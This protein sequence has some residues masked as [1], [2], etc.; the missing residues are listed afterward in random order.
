MISVVDAA[1]LIS[2]SNFSPFLGADQ[3]I[4]AVAFSKVLPG[5]FCQN[6][7]DI[8]CCRRGSNHGCT[9][10][11]HLRLV[12]VIVPTPLARSCTDDVDQIPSALPSLG[13]GA[14]HSCFSRDKIKLRE[15]RDIKWASAGGIWLAQS[16]PV[17]GAVGAQFPK[18]RM[19][20][21]ADAPG[22]DNK[23]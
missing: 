2:S 21:P 20:Y 10:I 8:D 18:T 16:I 11:F 12:A 9:V 7:I 14:F 5:S 23:I 15:L 22:R 13:R 17:I 19:R 6:I 3:V 4:P 1:D